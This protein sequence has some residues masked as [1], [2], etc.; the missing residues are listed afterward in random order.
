[1]RHAPSEMRAVASEILLALGDHVAAYNVSTQDAWWDY[2]PKAMSPDNFSTAAEYYKNAVGSGLWKKYQDF[3]GSAEAR[4]AATREKWYQA[5]KQCFRTNS[6]FD[7]YFDH[8]VFASL[9]PEVQKFLLDLRA[10]VRRVM[11]RVPTSLKPKFGPG[12]TY[13]TKGGVECTVPSKISTVPGL[14]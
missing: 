10:E 7:S 11:G 14:S 12:A 4:S 2:L 1:M 6:R 13:A 9:E 5:E 3:P 8:E